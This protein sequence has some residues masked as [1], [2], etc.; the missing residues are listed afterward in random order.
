MTRHRAPHRV[1]SLLLPLLVLLLAT[2]C[3]ARLPP[4]AGDALRVS[5]WVGEGDPQRRA[6]TRMVVE[7][8]EA[9]ARGR[10]ALA[11]A[12]FERALQVDPSNPLAYLALARHAAFEGDPERALAFLDK[13]EASF[14]R[15]AEGMLATPHLRGVRGVALSALGRRRESYPHL[16]AARRAA[17]VWSDG[18]LDA[19]ELR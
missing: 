12:S 8:L 18:Q 10:Q 7:G 17:A 11:I 13:A 19:S 6:S 3:V 14:G 16:D 9:S 2:G 5:S 1:A 4:A 15:S